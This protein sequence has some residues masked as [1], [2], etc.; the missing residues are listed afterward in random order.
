M[1]ICS[2]YYRLSSC[3]GGQSTL[4]ADAS[5]VPLD[6]LPIADQ[7]AQ[8]PTGSVVDSNISYI[9]QLYKKSQCIATTSVILNCYNYTCL[10]LHPTR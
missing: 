10:E 9:K 2:G 8:S 1:S 7:L 5:A 6:K 4:L 3:Q